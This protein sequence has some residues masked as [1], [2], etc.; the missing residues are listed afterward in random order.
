MGNKPK[1]VLQLIGT[2][3]C[4]GAETFLMNLL[5]NTDREKVI[6]DFAVIPDRKFF[7]S[8]EIEKLGGKIY[9]YPFKTKR[10]LLLPFYVF[11][12]IHVLLSKGPYEAVHSHYRFLNGVALGLAW[13]CG[14]KKRFS[15]S[16]GE[17]RPCRNPL[18]L[19]VR[20]VM[21]RLNAIFAT[22]L[23][24][25][26]RAAGISLYG[27]DAD[28]KV[29]N[30]GVNTAELAFSP[31]VRTQ[32]RDELGL[33]GKFALMH[34]GRFVKEKNHKFLLDVFAQFLKLKPNAVLLLAG[35][36]PLENDIRH[37]A[38]KLGVENK[39]KFLGFRNDVSAIL[40]A[41]DAFIMP[42]VREGLPLAAAEAQAAGLPCFFSDIITKEA[43]V[44]NVFFLPLGNPVVWAEEIAQ[45][46]ENFERRNTCS[47]LK[48]AGFDF[49]D[50]ALIMQHLYTE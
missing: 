10:T 41:A 32:K 24:A 4:G 23:L 20:P 26:S 6:F 11:T 34:T 19:L 25:C 9:S 39:I 13:L 17:D 30:N 18:P 16:H 42:S 31:A 22:K 7:Y 1:R 43:A 28:F 15:H 21:R 40:Q 5:R 49:K 47:V 29:I 14:V 37:K 12:V 3:D 27:M 8:A 35:G 33:S 50:S 45:T 44:C 2:M 48:T 36:G 38:K 46:T